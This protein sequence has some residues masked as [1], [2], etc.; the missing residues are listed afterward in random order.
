[1]YFSD[2]TIE[3]LSGFIRTVRLLLMLST[4]YFR[5]FIALNPCASTATLPFSKETVSEVLL[6]AT[7]DMIYVLR[8][9]EMRLTEWGVARITYQLTNCQLLNILEVRVKWGKKFQYGC[10][11]ETEKTAWPSFHMYI[12]NNSTLIHSL[13]LASSAT[14]LN[15]LYLLWNLAWVSIY[16][17]WPLPL[18]ATFMSR[19]H[20]FVCSSAI[21]MRHFFCGS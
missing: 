16:S 1:M 18:L 9:R 11:I 17:W 13:P 4:R 15:E 20:L 3:T 6:Y 12:C 14:D 7:Y 21:V 10:E 2:F 8:L 5:D 19:S